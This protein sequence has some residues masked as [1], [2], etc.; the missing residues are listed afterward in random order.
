M[1][2]F[3]APIA[4]FGCCGCLLFAGV[5]AQDEVAGEDAQVEIAL[6]QGGYTTSATANDIAVGGVWQ[7]DLLYVAITTGGSLEENSFGGTDIVLISYTED[8]V[9]VETTQIGG[10]GD[11]IIK[12][13]S[14]EG[15]TLTGIVIVGSTAVSDDDDSDLLFGLETAPGETDWFIAI[16]DNS[17]N[18]ANAYVNGTAFDV[19]QATAVGADADGE[20]YYV[21]GLTFGDYI[22]DNLG[23]GTSDAWVL[24]I[25]ADLDDI[26]WQWQF[27]TTVNDVPS[28]LVVGDSA[29]YVVGTTSDFDGDLTSDEEEETAPIF[30][31]AYDLEDGGDGEEWCV[32]NDEIGVMSDATEAHGAVLSEDGTELFV[33]G[34][35]EGVIPGFDGEATDGAELFVMSVDVDDGTVN[36]VWQSETNAT[37]FG[38]GGVVMADDGVSPI[39]AGIAFGNLFN[40]SFTYWEGGSGDMVAAKIDPDD[41]EVSKYY[42][43]AAATNLTREEAFAMVKDPD[44]TDG[45]FLIGAQDGV[46]DD[47]DFEPEEDPD[48]ESGENLYNY[49]TLKVQLEVLPEDEEEDTGPDYPYWYIGVPLFAAGGI[50]FVVAYKW[51]AASQAAKAKQASM[52]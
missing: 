26:E 20:G 5:K 23:T 42:V 36:W 24:K 19:E 52:I 9:E 25:N 1:R 10:S 51:S 38:R 32:A 37:A 41:L 12:A 8:L 7:D 33:S 47:E 48:S 45:V 46:F 18:V 29:V 30:V 21:A 11:D 13:I 50:L 16:V 43:A 6:A 39:V 49:L 3:A 28:A 15:S 4:L 2:C 34:H 40:L 22:D 27:G 17:L 44:V 14:I 35:T 31:C